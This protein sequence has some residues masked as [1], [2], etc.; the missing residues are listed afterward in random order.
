VK[1][2]TEAEYA[3]AQAAARTAAN[4]ARGHKAAATTAAEALAAAQAAHAAV[5]ASAEARMLRAEVRAAAA[6]AGAVDAADIIALLPQADIKRD[7]KGEPT[8]LGELIDAMKAAKPHLFGQPPAAPRSTSTP[9]SP[10]P[11]AEPKAK[12]AKEMTADEYKAERER[13][14]KMR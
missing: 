3:E 10:P 1:V 14:R 8:N 13:I 4:E 2:Y 5:V 6:A 7:E 9:A 12:H 11:P